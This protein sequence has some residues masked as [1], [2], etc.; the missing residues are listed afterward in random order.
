MDSENDYNIGKAIVRG[1]SEEEWNT[2]RLGKGAWPADK[3]AW[4]VFR[5]YSMEKLIDAMDT[6]KKQGK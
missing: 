4:K 3:D 1:Q 5:N 2:L 6:Y